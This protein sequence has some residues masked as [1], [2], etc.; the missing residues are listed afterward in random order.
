MMMVADT[1]G[2]GERELNHFQFFS[3]LNVVPSHVIKI[4]SFCGAT[5]NMV[6]FFVSDFNITLSRICN[7]ACDELLPL[8]VRVINCPLF[9]L[10][11]IK[12]SVCR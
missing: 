1:H 5:A 2:L 10:I 12:K 11:C 9:K 7:A 8:R 6:F 3:L 4:G